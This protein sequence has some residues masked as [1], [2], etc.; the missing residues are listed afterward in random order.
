[1]QT[2]ATN[3]FGQL[4]RNLFKLHTYTYTGSRPDLNRLFICA[5]YSWL[6]KSDPVEGLF[7]FLDLHK[8]WVAVGTRGL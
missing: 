8:T 7:I 4:I 3:E 6:I 2:V 5:R 1:M